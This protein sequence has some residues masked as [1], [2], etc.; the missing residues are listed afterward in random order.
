[1]NTMKRE[2]A[3]DTSSPQGTR[4]LSLFLSSMISTLHPTADNIHFSSLLIPNIP[5]RSIDHHQSL[6]FRNVRF[7]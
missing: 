1:M 6:D 3:P 4:F 2:R 5:E 7:P